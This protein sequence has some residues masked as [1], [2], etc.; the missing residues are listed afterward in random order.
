MKVKIALLF[1]ATLGSATLIASAQ[2]ASY[3]IT[4]D[5]PPGQREPAKTAVL[6]QPAMPIRTPGAVTTNSYFTTLYGSRQPVLW[7][8]SG[9]EAGLSG[10]AEQLVQQLAGAKSDSDRDKL[11][12]QLAEILEKQFDQRQKRHEEELK[13]LETQVKK[14]KDLVD[15]RQENRRD[16]IRARLTQIEKESQGLGW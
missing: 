3:V 4:P 13:E 9:E 11:K 5:A 6:A 10:Q 14:L 16:I 8:L 7:T 1:V 12:G 2:Q 15:K